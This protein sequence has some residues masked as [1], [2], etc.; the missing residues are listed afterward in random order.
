MKTILNV[1]AFLMLSTFTIVSC[2]KDA[3]EGNA[4]RL[5]DV[6]QSVIDKLHK[7]GFGT[8]SVTVHENGYVVEGDMLITKEQLDA[9]PDA[10]LLRVGEEEQYRTYNLVTGLPRTIKVRLSGS[11]SSS[12]LQKHTAALDEAL[13]RY[14]A[15]GLGLTFQ[16]VASTATADVSVSPGVGMPYGLWALANFPTASGQPNNYVLVNVSM[17]GSQPQNTIASIL[18]HELGHCIGFRHTNYAANGETPGSDGA[19]HIP[20]T[21]TGSDPTSWM[22]AAIS[23]GQNRPFN[24][25]DVIAL[26]YLYPAPLNNTSIYGDWNITRLGDMALSG[27]YKVYIEQPSTSRFKG[28]MDCNNFWGTYTLSGANS[29]TFVVT[30]KT[31][32]SCNLYG[33]DGGLSELV[34]ALGRVTGYSLINNGK[35]LNLIESNGYSH[36][37]CTRP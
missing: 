35:G 24:N 37:G 6:P 23:S 14:N 9:T 28:A 15:L 17:T 29:I 32:N 20:G 13:Q 18:A 3:N 30:Q 26:K 11:W 1:A 31:S 27:P 33:S 22:L 8:Q 21:P 10:K 5:N 16:R 25:N 36:I 2:K 4:E 7:L 12:M 19:I 34:G